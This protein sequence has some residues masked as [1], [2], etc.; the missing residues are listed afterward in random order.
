MENKLKFIIEESVKR[1]WGEIDKKEDRFK[2][3]EKDGLI[4]LLAVNF[5]EGIASPIHISSIFFSH[6]W[7]K[8][9]FG[10]EVITYKESEGRTKSNNDIYL[11]CFSREYGKSYLFHLSKLVQLETDEERVDYVYQYLKDH[12]EKILPT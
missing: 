12:D 2:F 10:E 5:L 3:F 1:G 11:E 9:V 7:A 8:C 6:D 4:F